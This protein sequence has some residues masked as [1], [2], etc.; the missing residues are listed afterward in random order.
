M[1]C[2]L[3]LLLIKTNEWWL[4]WDRLF[5]DAVAAVDAVVAADAVDA[6]ANVDVYD[7]DDVIAD[8]DAVALG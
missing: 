4:N 6:V 5:S 8:V 3:L 7:A 1:P 2:F